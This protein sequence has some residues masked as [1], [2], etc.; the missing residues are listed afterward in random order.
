MSRIACRNMRP[1]VGG[2]AG[3]NVPGLMAIVLLR[4][5]AAV[6]GFAGWTRG[7]VV[8]VSAL[9]MFAS[10]VRAARG[11][12]RGY[13]RLRVTVAAMLALR[14][15]FWLRMKIEQSACGLIVIGVVVIVKGKHRR[16]LSAAIRLAAGPGS[17]PG[18]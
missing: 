10:A 5:D 8:V 18:R 3:I 11:C 1:V 7:T 15:A 14:G 4:D 6:V 2:Y 17:L 16:S 13:L 12:R 9:L